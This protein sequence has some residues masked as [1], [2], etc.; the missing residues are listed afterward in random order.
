MELISDLRTHTTLPS[1][2]IYNVIANLVTSNLGIVF[3]TKSDGEF[4]GTISLGDAKRY[5]ASGGDIEVKCEKIVNQH[6]KYVSF[7]NIENAK[8]L[9]SDTIGCIPVLGADG[10]LVSIAL[11]MP[12]AKVNDDDINLNIGSAQYH[13]EGFIDL[14]LPSD[15]YDKKRTRDFVAYDIRNDKIPYNDSSVSN[16]YCSHV[17]EHLEDKPVDFFIQNCF[18]V[19]KPGGVLRLACPDANFLWNVSQFEND[20][21]N[22][23]QYWFDDGNN[24][25]AESFSMVTKEDQLI[26]ALATEKCQYYIH[27]KSDLNPLTIKGL[28]YPETLAVL[29]KGLK[30]DVDFLG[31]HV[32]QWD[33]EQLNALGSKAG[34]RHIVRSKYRGSVSSVM[35]GKQF[36]LTW[37]TISLYVD[38]VK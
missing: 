30:Y 33:Y 15:W 1:D 25:N 8:R 29:K 32:N 26:R 2:K 10:K 6:A 14:D 35:Q 22:F 37:P 9:F 20:Y 23:M 19:L 4:L 38:M 17:I 24:S 28:G 31:N 3:C 12:E 7:A 27:K 18:R 5:I 13:I 21:W 34:F 36:D 16:I 11:G